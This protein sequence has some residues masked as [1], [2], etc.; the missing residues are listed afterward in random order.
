MHRGVRIPHRLWEGRL[1]SR[2]P[3][4]ADG[5]DRPG[6]TNRRG[7]T[8]ARITLRHSETGGAQRPPRRMVVTE[9]QHVVRLRDGTVDRVLSPGRHRFRPWR[10]RIGSAGEGPRRDCGPLQPRQRR[11]S[12][13]GQPRVVPTAPLSGDRQF[14]R[15]HIPHRNRTRLIGKS[16]LLFRDP[17]RRPR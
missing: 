13:Q 9:L 17:G 15:K 2:E 7:G 3:P 5:A 8:M 12:P 1:R 11:V 16:P 6:A 10:D 14:V 4:P